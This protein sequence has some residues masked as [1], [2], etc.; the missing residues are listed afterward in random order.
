MFIGQKGI[1]RDGHHVEVI[2]VQGQFAV[3]KSRSGARFTLHAAEFFPDT[4]TKAERKQRVQAVRGWPTTDFSVKVIPGS[5]G[6]QPSL[7]VAAIDVRESNIGKALYQRVTSDERQKR[8]QASR[9]RARACARK[10]G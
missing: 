2:E 1:T 6:K 3:V 8:A 5:D 4:D 7:Q 9:A 10:E